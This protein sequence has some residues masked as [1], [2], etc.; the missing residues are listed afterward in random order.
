MSNRNNGLTEVIV[1]SFPQ[2]QKFKYPFELDN[3]GGRLKSS[4]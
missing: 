3:C 1:K 2:L 4:S